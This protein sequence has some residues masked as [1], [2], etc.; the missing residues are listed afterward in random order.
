MRVTCYDCSTQ[1]KRGSRR[2]PFMMAHGQSRLT[3]WRWVPML[4]SPNSGFEMGTI[5]F[6]VD[7]RLSNVKEM[8]VVFSA[9][10]QAVDGMILC[11]FQKLNS[12]RQ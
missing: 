4:R 8:T 6:A 3:H 1:R 11:H 2:A 5:G 9:R 12:A 7:A 10:Y